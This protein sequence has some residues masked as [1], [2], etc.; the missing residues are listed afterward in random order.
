MDVHTLLKNAD[1]AMYKAKQGGKNRYQFYA[2]HMQ[3]DAQERVRMESDLRS[4]IAAQS[5]VLHYQP[6]VDADS[7]ELV[8]AEALLRWQH[9]TRGM[10]HPLDFIP[11]AEDCGLIVPI[12]EW[13]LREAAR[14]WQAWC[15]QG[16][17]P[18]SMSVNVSSLQI[19]EAGF[20]PLLQGIL[21][22]FEVTPG[23]LMLEITESVLMDSSQETEA[24]M[25]EVKALGVGY[26]LDDFG[27]GFSSLSY[28]KRFSVDVVKIDRSFIHDCPDDYND[29]HL[30]EAIINMAHSLNLKITA[31]GVENK[32]QFE[33]L[34]N[35]GCDMIQGYLIDRALPADAFV[36]LIERRQLLLPADGASLEETRFLAALRGD[37][38]DV[39][40]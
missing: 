36:N 16:Y 18:L 28:L 3:L 31:E 19:R 30:V 33:F 4:A 24:R 27:T 6:I 38:L 2:H 7:G 20:Y 8:G 1:I 17:P 21:S 37:E 12:G 14:Q 39:D 22:E 35:L 10:L 34:L 40:A 23:S 5:F 9:P 26:S 13:V 29:A 25:R 15:K 11:V 32:A